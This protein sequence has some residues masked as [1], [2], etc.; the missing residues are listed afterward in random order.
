MIAEEEA[1]R[2][3]SC[4]DARAGVAASLFGRLQVVQDSEDAR[5]E[6]VRPFLRREW[7]RSRLTDFLSGT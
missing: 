4:A 1:D 6:L 3:L 7:E 2:L 5:E